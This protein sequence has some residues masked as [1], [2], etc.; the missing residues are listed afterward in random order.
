MK[1]IFWSVITAI[2]LL[3]V[4]S[5]ILYSG[6]EEEV[7]VPVPEH[8]AA[9]ISDLQAT[10]EQMAD[11]YARMTE[12]AN[13]ALAAHNSSWLLEAENIQENIATLYDSKVVTLE[14][15]LNNE[16]LPETSGKQFAEFMERAKGLVS[17]ESRRDMLINRKNLGMTVE[18]DA[19]LELAVEYRKMDDMYD[20]NTGLSALAETVADYDSR[21]ANSIYRMMDAPFFNALRAAKTTDTDAGSLISAITDPYLALQ[22]LI[23]AGKKEI[24]SRGIDQINILL[25]R[26]TDANERAFMAA[27]VLT[28]LPNIPESSRSA[29]Y[30]EIEKS[31][32][33]LVLLAD[34]KLS[35]VENGTL[36]GPE[37]EKYLQDIRDIT[38]QIE[39]NYSRELILARM[40]ILDIDRPTEDIMAEAEALKSATLREQILTYT[41]VNKT[42]LTDE[43]IATLVEAMH[44]PYSKLITML[45]RFNEI[46]I[47][48]YDAEMFLEPLTGFADEVSELQPRID[49]LLAWARIDPFRTRQNL[50][51]FNTIHKVTASAAVVKVIEDDDTAKQIL[52]DVYTEVSTS[53]IFEPLEKAALLRNIGLAYHE[54]NSAKARQI[55]GEAFQLANQM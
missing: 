23:T 24:D 39:Q 30:T 19:W 20:R 52:D 36:S 44:D 34:T 25:S 46:S 4:I 12:F 54:F 38:G 42:G 10:V 8:I 28:M 16:E 45:D 5:L 35:L 32:D 29:F 33:Y 18:S 47:S 50:N 22:V 2:L 17:V 13:L 53:R 15:Q 11:N 40:I 43:E 3:A 37:Q 26:F 27:R 48:G 55:L 7:V 14:N 6:E 31:D 51:E 21:L 41:A 1:K 49:L 9:L